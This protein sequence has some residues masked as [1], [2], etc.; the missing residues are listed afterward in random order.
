M[1]DAVGTKSFLSFP[2]LVSFF[3]F[4]SLSHSH[5]APTQS[6]PYSPL[7]D[8]F[9]NLLTRKLVEVE[10]VVPAPLVIDEAYHDELDDLERC[11]LELE[12]GFADALPA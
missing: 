7:Q 4:L 12:E 8:K 9:F 11:E 1:P 3:P 2:S 5:Q 6:S 10:V